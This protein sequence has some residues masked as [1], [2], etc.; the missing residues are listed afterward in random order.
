MVYV[1]DLTFDPEDPGSHLKI[2]NRVAAS[3]IAHLVHERY[4]LSQSLVVAFQAL[5]QDGDIERVLSCYRDLMTQRDINFSDLTKTDEGK[6]RDSFYFSLLRNHQLLPLAE[7]Q[8]TK[9]IHWLI[10]G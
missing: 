1:G 8:V 6:H 4:Q 3:R 2:P 9:V 7:F 10:I 5:A